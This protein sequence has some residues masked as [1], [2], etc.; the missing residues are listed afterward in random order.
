MKVTSGFL[1]LLAD[2]F[3]R[4]LDSNLELTNLKYEVRELITSSTYVSF[5]PD[6]EVDCTEMEIVI[7]DLYETVLLKMIQRLS[8]KFVERK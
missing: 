3:I 5:N 8:D 1:N 4:H 6:D 2:D 7:T